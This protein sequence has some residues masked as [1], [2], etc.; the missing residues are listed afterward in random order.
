ME[1]NTQKP[2]KKLN[3]IVIL[4]IAVVILLGVI[5]GKRYLDNKKAQEEAV[6][7]QIRYNQIV[8]D[9][10]DSA[11]MIETEGNLISNVWSNA[12][13]QRSDSKTDKYTKVNGVFVEDFNDAIFALE[14]DPEYTEAISKIK[15]DRQWIKQEMKELID[16][17]KGFEEA[18]KALKPLYDSYLA[19]S[20]IVLDLNGSLQTFNEKFSAEDE[21]FMKQYNNAEL[22]VK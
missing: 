10:L 18:Y 22:Y 17:P 7:Y 9:I 6:E 19:F 13:F 2:V 3:I 5:L 15:E 21:N 20:N 11:C 4:I 14:S 16:P 8:S 12:I 1:E